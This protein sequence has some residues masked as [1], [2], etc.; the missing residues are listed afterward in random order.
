MAQCV[1]IFNQKASI[2]FSQRLFNNQCGKQKE[3]QNN[4]MGGKFFQKFWTYLKK[5]VPVSR[6]VQFW[7]V[8]HPNTKVDK[9]LVLLNFL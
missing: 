4:K 6:L 3:V 1:Y 2:N 8:N 5:I 9:V 7:S